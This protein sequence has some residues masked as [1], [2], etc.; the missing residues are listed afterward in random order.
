MLLRDVHGERLHGLVEAPVDLARKHLGAAD[1]QLEPLPP[2]RLDEHGELQ[3][4]PP[5]HGPGVGP[6]GREDADGDV[7]DLLRLEAALDE[8]SRE[9]SALASRQGRRV[10][11]DGDREAGFVDPDLGQR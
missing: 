10:D 1:G 11:P 5:L 8:P 6:F 7:P 4:A 3:L 2:Q 9:L